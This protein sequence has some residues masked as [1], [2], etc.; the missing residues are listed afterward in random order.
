MI[1]GRKKKRR[2]TLTRTLEALIFSSSSLDSSFLA[3]SRS[4]S[5]CKACKSIDFNLDIYIGA[6]GPPSWFFY[7]LSCDLTITD[8]SSVHSGYNSAIDLTRTCNQLLESIY[9]QKR[10]KPRRIVA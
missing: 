8:D 2:G 1:Q 6:H 3:A 5:F 7:L 9:H 10:A 4:S